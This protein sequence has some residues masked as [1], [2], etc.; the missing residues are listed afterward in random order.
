M[1][2]ISSVNNEALDSLCECDSDVEDA[3]VSESTPENKPV[4]VRRSACRLPSFDRVL[5]QA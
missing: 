3:E 1:K 5:T 4:Q 2:E